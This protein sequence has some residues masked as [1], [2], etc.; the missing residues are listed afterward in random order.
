MNKQV[1]VGV[2]GAGRIGKLHINNM[3]NLSGVRIKAVSD[4]FADHLQDWFNTSGVEY[5][6]KDYQEIIQDPEIDAIFIC[7][8]TDTHVEIIKE[9]AKKGKHIFCEKPISFS[10]EETLEAYEAVK[11]AGVK[12]QIGFNRRFDRNFSKVRAAVEEKGIGDLHVLKITSRDPE[13]PALDYVE[14]SGGIF[15]DMTIHDF[16]MARFIS[17]SEV[18]EV[19]ATG[20]ALVNPAIANYNDIDTAIINLKF[21]NGSIG[22]IDNSRQAVYG[23]DQRLEAF[24]SEGSAIV[25]NETESTV[26]ISS[27]NGIQEDKP[28]HFF[29]ERYNDAFVKEIKGFFDAITHDTEVPC[30][31]QDGIMA[32]RIAVA[33]KESLQTGVPVSVETTIKLELLN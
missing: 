24:G 12:F 2:V 23:Y 29:L 8:P 18:I 16:D 21:A 14:R 33:A 4:V 6:T 9:A 30:Q 26:S 17:G 22:V 19:F 31:F 3:K 13:P 10:Q 28:L 25:N 15:M 11:E 5:L 20:A 1:V 32:Q 7:S 27:R